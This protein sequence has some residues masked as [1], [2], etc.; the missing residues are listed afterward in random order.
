MRRVLEELR[1]SISWEER[2]ER[3][4][5]VGAAEAPQPAQVE[6]PGGPERWALQRWQSVTGEP[7]AIRLSGPSEPAEH[8]CELLLGALGDYARALAGLG[9]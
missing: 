1:G 2:L 9:A 3:L 7:P 6:G 5:P 8:E 4:I